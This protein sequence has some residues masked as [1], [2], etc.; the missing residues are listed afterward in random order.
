MDRKPANR[1]ESQRRDY[2]RY[3]SWSRSRVAVQ[4]AVYEMDHASDR[5]AVLFV[6]K[7]FVSRRFKKTM[8]TSR[9][10]REGFTIPSDLNAMDCSPI[11]P[12]VIL[13]FSI[14]LKFVR[15]HKKFHF[16]V[17]GVTTAL[18][19]TTAY[20]RSHYCYRVSFP[21]VIK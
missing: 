10:A 1:P 19:V 15:Y 21:R 2:S 3:H 4:R 17:V 12:S 14:S 18:V 13:C 5:V 7:S 20:A 9:R 16:Y 6:N 11:F 8:S